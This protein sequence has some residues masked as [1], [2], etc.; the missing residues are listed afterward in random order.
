[1][2]NLEDSVAT[3]HREKRERRQKEREREKREK[4]ENERERERLF[5]RLELKEKK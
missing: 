2:P 1:L 5:G 4:R 3:Y